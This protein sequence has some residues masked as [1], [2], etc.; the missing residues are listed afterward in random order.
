M[1]TT[2]IS[3]ILK[4]KKVYE[5][6]MRTEFSGLTKPF[7]IILKCFDSFTICPFYKTLSQD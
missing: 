7:H 3:A 2:F 1:M 6:D 5:A 4:V